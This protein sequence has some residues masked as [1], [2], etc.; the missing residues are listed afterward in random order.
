MK[1]CILL[2]HVF[3]RKTE[4]SKLDKVNF[5]VEHYR[6]NNPNSYIIATGHGKKP[7]RIDEYCDFVYWKEQIIESEINY[8]H[9]ILVNKGIDHAIDKGFDFVL[10]TRLDS[11]HLKK[12]IYLYALENL[13]DKL[14]L[15]SQISA[16]DSPTLCDLFNFS[17][18]LFMKKCWDLKNWECKEKSGLEYHAEN[19]K[20]A[21]QEYNW[22]ECI[23]KYCIIKNI[24]N[25]KWI[26]FR[27][28]SNWSILKHYKKNLIN[29]DLINFR[30]YLWGTKEGWIV[31]NRNGLLE[32]S[33]TWNLKNLITEEDLQKYSK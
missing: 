23:R 3:I 25:L 11:I 15:T 7:S 2:S 5:A 1:E 26:D 13:K 19:F 14:Y 17:S 33:N 20:I 28:N 10:K 32:S 12:N 8:G 6:T 16:W 30:K 4:F 22:E 27:P 29:N 21:C 18:T 31:W 9:P 24:Y